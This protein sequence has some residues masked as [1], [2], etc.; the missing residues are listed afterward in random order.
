MVESIV[1]SSRKFRRRD[2]ERRFSRKEASVVVGSS[3]YSCSI[4]WASRD[5][6]ASCSLNT[7]VN[8]K[9]RD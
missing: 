8:R 5:G 6:S 4:P 3:G 7:L 9:V 2:L 1:M